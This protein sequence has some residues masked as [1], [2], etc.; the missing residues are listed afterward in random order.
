MERLRNRAPRLVIAAK[1]PGEQDGAGAYEAELNPNPELLDI[2]TETERVKQ[3]YPK[4]GVASPLVVATV[5]GRIQPEELLRYSSGLD[6]FYRDYRG[7]LEK[8][9]EERHRLSMALAFEV[10]LGNCGTLPASDMDVELYLPDVFEHVTT[11]AE[12]EESLPRPP[13]P[14]DPPIAGPHPEILRALKA[15]RFPIFEYSPNLDAIAQLG[16]NVSQPKIARNSPVTISTHVMELK[17]H[18]MCSLGQFLAVF[19]SWDLVQPFEMEYRVLAAELPDPAT[20]KVP[21]IVKRATGEK[22]QS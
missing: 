13:L 2:D 6:R 21:F 16:A 9:N 8:A 19:R 7:Y 20:G 1:R 3:E 4:P 10:T 18:Q 12:A 15:V 11:L 5:E 14:P 17:H 22:R